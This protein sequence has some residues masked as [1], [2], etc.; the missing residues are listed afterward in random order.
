MILR[1]QNV[2][3]DLNEARKLERKRFKADAKQME[4]DL[5]NR[6]AEI[7][8]MEANIEYLTRTNDALKRTVLSLMNEQ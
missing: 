5:N 6:D 4:R 8:R 2:L 3:S 1:P 7:A